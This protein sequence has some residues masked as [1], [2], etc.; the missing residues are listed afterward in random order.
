MHIPAD[1]SPWSAPQPDVWRA[2]PAGRVLCFAPHP[3]DECI[4]PGGLLALHRRQGDP[5]RVVVASDGRAGDPDGKFDAG[6]YTER[7]RA[8]TRAGLHE[9]G[10]DDVGFWGLPDSCVITDGD[11]DLLAGLA[12]AEIDSYAPEIVYMPWE[13]EGNSDHRALFCGVFRALK[14]RAWP[15]RALGY[16]IWNHLVPDVLVDIT[17]VIDR[18]ERALRGFATQLAYTDIL[19]P[20]LGLNAARSMIFNNGVGYGEALRRVEVR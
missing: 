14:R 19:R 5:V 18:K 7:R 13:G 3:D 2:P 6:S 17:D 1:D 11:L 16:E 9:L 15:G 4:G 8:E 12:Q 20:T 10:V